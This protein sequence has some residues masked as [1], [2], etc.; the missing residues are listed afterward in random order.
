MNTVAIV[1]PLVFVAVLFVVGAVYV[2][3]PSQRKVKFRQK[4]NTRT[5][6]TNDKSAAIA[7]IYSP[8]ELLA[9][10]KDNNNQESKMH[11]NLKSLIANSGLSDANQTLLACA[12]SF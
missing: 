12:C 11:R 9:K 7:P 8:N 4:I 1:V 5:I 10:R 6:N 3:K 2:Y